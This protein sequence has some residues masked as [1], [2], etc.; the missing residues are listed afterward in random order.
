MGATKL[1]TLGITLV[2]A[3]GTVVACNRVGDAYCDVGTDLTDPTDECPFGPPGGPGSHNSEACPDIPIDKTAAA[4]AGVSW[5]SL[6]NSQLKTNCSNG[7]CHDDGKGA[8][9]GG[10]YLPAGDPI[11]GFGTLKRYVLATYPYVSDDEPE[12]TWILCNLQKTK[13]GGAGMPLG[14][15]LPMAAMTAVETWAK[16]GEPMGTAT[17]PPMMDA[18]ADAPTD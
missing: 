9:A 13:S 15:D 16:C 6:W 5:V 1:Q 17:P 10:I 14:F 3:V 4:C 18:G 7:G 2:L 8:G 12:H 11:A